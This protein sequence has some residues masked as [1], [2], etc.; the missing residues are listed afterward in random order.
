MKEVVNI[1]GTE[2]TIE[3]HKVSEDTYLKKR[4]LS[5]YCAE[6]SK[7]IVVADVSEKEYFDGMDENEQEI[8]Q[9]KIL[10]HE[11]IHAFLNESGLSDS[12]STPECA[13]AKYEEMIDWIAIQSPKIFKVFQELDI[14]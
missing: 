5:G 4:C 9:K 3:T 8:Y 2:Y 7:L 12:A 14:I 13:W 1:L 6:E 11:I 10:R